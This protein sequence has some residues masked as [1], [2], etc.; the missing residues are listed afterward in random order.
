MRPV[1][2]R[3]A[4]PRRPRPSARACR[5]L[6]AAGGLALSALLWPAVAGAAAS[7]ARNPAAPNAAPHDAV[8]VF[9]V[10]GWHPLDDRRGVIWLGV[11]EPYL[12]GVRPSCPPLDTTALMAVAVG[13]RH[14]VP[15][16]DR[17][18]FAGSPACVIDSLVRAD[19]N[20]LRDS[21]IAPDPDPAIRLLQEPVPRHAR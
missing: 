15:G 16:R 14:L 18:M 17:L 12:V 7:G 8:R 11:D 10:Y 4:P 5:R 2:Q 9:R 21:A 20:T 13:G 6:A 1:R 19:R 3:C